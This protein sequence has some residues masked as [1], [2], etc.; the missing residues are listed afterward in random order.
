MQE[1]EVGFQKGRCGRLVSWARETRGA[2][3]ALS[4]RGSA[5]SRARGKE[6]RYGNV[7]VCVMKV[8]L[9]GEGKVTNSWNYS[10]NSFNYASHAA[11]HGSRTQSLIQS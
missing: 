4:V 7:W 3:Q 5:W 10:P 9:K 8:C 6:G 1:A 11:N 2:A